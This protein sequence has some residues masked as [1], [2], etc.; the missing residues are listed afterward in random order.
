V[1]NLGPKRTGLGVS[2][3]CPISAPG[4]LF[5][6]GFLGFL[7]LLRF[8]AW[9]LT[10]TMS[11]LSTA[12]VVVFA[13]LAAAYMARWM[14]VAAESSADGYDDVPGP[15]DPRVVE[16]IFGSLVKFIATM[17]FCMGPLALLSAFGLNVG[18]VPYIVLVLGGIYLPMALLGMAVKEEIGGCFPGTV[19]PAVVS[20][21]VRYLPAAAIAVG[22]GWVLQLT[23][24]GAL[25]RSPIV[26]K[27]ALDLGV[28]YLVLVMLHRVGVIYRESSILKAIIQRAE[29]V[30]LDLSASVGSRPMTD[31]ERILAER[32]KQES[33]GIPPG[34]R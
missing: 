18:P 14:L 17:F 33:Q 19:I 11:G 3:T 13:V 4:I 15:P 16:E 29:P 12:F 28:S 30:K 1:L 2:L 9:L 8:I 32:E 34:P 6:L 25:A 7:G 20:S 22:A 10:E 31:I 23:W 24:D 21:F 27:V 5:V 26:V